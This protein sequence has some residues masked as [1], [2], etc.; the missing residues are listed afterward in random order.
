VFRVF[1]GLLIFLESV[2]AIFTGWVKRTLV[3]P[4]FTFSFIG[5]EWL[6]PLPGNGMYFYFLLMG[7]LGLLVMI[8][9]KYRWSMLGFAVLWA[10]VYFMQKASYNNHYYLLMILSFV[11]VLVPANTYLSV[12]AK[13]NPEIKSI[14]MYNW[15]K[16]LIIGLMT[17]AYTFGAI[18]KV[19]ADWLNAIPVQQFMYAKAHY[20]LI[21]DLLQ[22]RWVHYVLSYMGIIFDAL[23]VPALLYKPTRKYAFYCA[24]FFHLFNSVVF[25][26]GIFPFLSLAFCLFF[27]EAETIRNI[28]LKQ[29]ELYTA[30]EIEI[31]KNAALIKYGVLLF[32][33][34]QLLLPLRHWFIQDDVLWTEEGH[35]MS[36]RMMLRTKT[37]IITYKV[38]DKANQK[39]D[40]I[41]VR[42][43]VSPKQAGMLS[44][45]P[46]VIWQFVQRLKTHYKKEGKTIEVYALNSKIS[47]NGK[48]YEPFVNPKVDLA[49]VSWNPFKHSDW[50][51]PSPQSKEI[52][53]R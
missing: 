45:K 18:N 25:Q 21:G 31:P 48:K 8:G 13:L 19:Y 38:I 6:Q 9:Y 33:A 35:R 1:F 44:T 7:I 22:Q 26:V 49:S 3:D 40:F 42:K 10:G 17:I 5:F 27:F 29:K 15:Q 16:W 36:W 14:K 39:A 30:N 51:L 11:M 20:F 28:F 53:E 12:D 46:D 52:D 37:G 2:G 23:I 43:W 24:I 50:L 4:E 34:I 32:F 47:V 41:D